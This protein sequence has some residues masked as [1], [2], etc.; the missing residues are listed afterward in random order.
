MAAIT[1]T[2][3]TIVERKFLSVIGKITGWIICGDGRIAGRA[4]VHH[5]SLRVPSRCVDDVECITAAGL[6]K[7][8]PRLY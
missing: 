8:Q 4:R 3:K 7:L 2:A 1:T 5:Q 6:N